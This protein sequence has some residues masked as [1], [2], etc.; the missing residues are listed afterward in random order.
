LNS[1]KVEG[2]SAVKRFVRQRQQGVSTVCLPLTHLRS[3]ASHAVDCDDHCEV[4]APNLLPVL[5]KFA[6][7]GR[8]DRPLRDPM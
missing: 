1:L 5:G 2:S 6:S 8:L 3:E 4:V 7:G